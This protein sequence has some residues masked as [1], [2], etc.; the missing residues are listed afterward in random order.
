MIDHYYSNNATYESY[1]LNNEQVNDD[2]TDSNI[3]YKYR[4]INSFHYIIKYK[5]FHLLY[6][7]T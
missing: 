5:D 6:N 4:Y 2:Y 3:I 7:K 1:V